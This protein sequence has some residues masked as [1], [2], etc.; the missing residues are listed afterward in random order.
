MVFGISCQVNGHAKA[1]DFSAAL[2]CGVL[3]L[4]LEQ[5]QVARQILRCGIH[6]TIMAYDARQRQCMGAKRKMKTGVDFP[7]LAN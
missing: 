7:L 5:V 2:I 4:L 1:G 6:G 3:K